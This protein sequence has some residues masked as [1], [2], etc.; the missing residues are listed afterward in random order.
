[1]RGGVAP[2]P[3]RGGNRRARAVRRQHASSLAAGRAR[4]VAG[5]AGGLRHHAG[6]RRAGAGV[7]ALGRPGRHGALPQSRGAAHPHSR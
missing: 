3:G 2:E 7:G 5:E 1:M 4:A 6:I